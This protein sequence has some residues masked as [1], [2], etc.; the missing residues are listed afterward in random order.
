MR[1]GIS[2]LLA[3]LLLVSI[4]SLAGA[5]ALGARDETIYVLMDGAGGILSVNAV[6]R[7]DVAAGEYEDDGA[8]SSVTALSGAEVALDGE[9]VRILAAKDG[10]VYY[11]GELAQTAVPWFVSLSFT[12]EGQPLSAASRGRAPLSRR[13]PPA[14]SAIA[15]AA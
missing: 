4:P 5:E 7:A 9:T 12:Q 11:Q 13:P 14:R 1:K 6:V 10:A 15:P 8:Y 3:A 2:V